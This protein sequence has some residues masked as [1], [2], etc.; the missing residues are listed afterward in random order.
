MPLSDLLAD[1]HHHHPSPAR[2][3]LVVAASR[4]LLGFL[5]KI[6]MQIQSQ[7]S[8]MASGAVAFVIAKQ[9]GEAI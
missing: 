8:R 9:A 5:S 1:L 7:S 6:F 4:A 2:P 3:C